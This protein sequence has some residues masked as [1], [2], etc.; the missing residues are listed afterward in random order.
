MGEF[1]SV[2]GSH[3]STQREITMMRVMNTITEKPEWYRKV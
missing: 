3:L 1:N 2:L